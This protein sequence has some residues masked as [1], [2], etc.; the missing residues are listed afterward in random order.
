MP[1]WLRAGALLAALTLLGCNAQD[2]VKATVPARE[3]KA[4]QEYLDKIRT[5]DFAPIA[6]ASDPAIRTQI[7]PDILRN[8]RNAFGQAPLKSVKII[9][10]EA[11]NVAGKS[12]YTVA[13]E[14]ELGDRWVA[15]KI[16]LQAIGDRMQIEGVQTFP[17][18][19]S[20]EEQTEFTLSGKSPGQLTFLAV[21]ITNLIFVIGTA[22]ICWRT[23]IPRRKWLWRI[24]VLFG[25]GS[26]TLNWMT[27]AIQLQLFSVLLFGA[28]FFKPFYQPVII[29]VGLPIGAL[30]FWLRRPAWRKA[31]QAEAQS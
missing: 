12:A 4:G 27:S 22:V 16:T 7:T 30:V 14:Y 9:A 10:G 5:G 6:D 18:A 13:Y 21:A 8:I 15:A 17:L 2:I 28:G 29:Q 3:A 20:V 23:P 19:R 31:R 26:A 1:K 11:V 24:F 25:F